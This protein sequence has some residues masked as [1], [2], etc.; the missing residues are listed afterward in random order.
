MA[1]WVYN[2][3]DGK[4]AWMVSCSRPDRSQVVTWLV[5]GG[6]LKQSTL[7]PLERQRELGG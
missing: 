5:A 3:G 1:K 7:P 2:F 4:V 6:G